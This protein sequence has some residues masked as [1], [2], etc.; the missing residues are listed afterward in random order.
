MHVKPHGRQDAKVLVPKRPNTPHKTK[1]K[2]WD[3]PGMDSA[4]LGSSIRVRVRTGWA[5]QDVSNLNARG[6]GLGETPLRR[7]EAVTE[8]GRSQAQAPPFTKA[9]R[10]NAKLRRWVAFTEL[11]SRNWVGRKRSRKRVHESAPPQ[12]QTHR[13]RYNASSYIGRLHR[14]VSRS[15]VPCRL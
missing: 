2:G 14:P 1:H 8:M 13:S 7:W 5:Q 4:R 10:H 9:R 15:V 3:G 6:F 11:G 12:R